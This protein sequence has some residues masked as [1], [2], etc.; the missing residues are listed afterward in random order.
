MIDFDNRTDYNFDI[1]LLEKIASDWTNRDIELILTDDSEIKKINKEFR[2]IDKPTDVI[3]FPLAETPNSPLGVIVISIDRV[4]E[5][6][7]NYGHSPSDELA[8][9][10][11][12]RL[13]HLLGYDHEIDSGQMR[14][15][16]KEIIKRYELPESLI[17]RSEKE[18]D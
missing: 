11:I 4:L 3:S 1:H 2:N 7:Q 5:A 16:E 10:F 6:A 8:L 9:L 18:G 17:V 13:L 14:E 12:H 15:K